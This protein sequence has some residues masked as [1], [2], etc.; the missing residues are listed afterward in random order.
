MRSGSLK[1]YSLPAHAGRNRQN[2]PGA[3]KA[4]GEGDGAMTRASLINLA[5]YSEAPDSL[6]NN[7]QLISQITENHACRAIVIAADPA[8]RTTKLRPG[9][10]RI[11]TSST[12]RQQTSLLRTDLIPAQRRR[13]PRS[14]EHCFFQSRFRPSALSLV[15]GRVSRSDGS[16]TLGLG[17]S[18]DLRQ[19]GWSDF[20]SQMHL[21]E[22]MQQGGQPTYRP[23]RFELDAAGPPSLRACAILRSS[24]FASS[25][26]QDQQGADRFCTR[27]QIDRDL[28]CGLAG[29]AIE[30]AHRR[31][32]ISRSA[33]VH[34]SFRAT[35][36]SR[37]S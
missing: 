27:V 35:N 33:A 37:A 32:E 2:R 19:P 21:L 8:Q 13:A 24:R 34:R 30:L 26:R 15:A 3:E 16:A 10:A 12:R 14:A 28:V 18:R 7:T 29:S 25:P 23:L 6:Q 4:L 36:R 1:P 17:R 31:S 20:R 9:S 5:V 11:A 22:L